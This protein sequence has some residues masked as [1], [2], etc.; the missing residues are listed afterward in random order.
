MLM[1]ARARST[2]GALLVGFAVLLLGACA[3]GGGGAA[4]SASP[5]SR[6]PLDAGSI[7]VYDDDAQCGGTSN[8][9]KVENPFYVGGSGLAPN[10]PF[11]LTFVTQPGGETVL[12]LTGTTTPE[13]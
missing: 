3:E 4:S 1:S 10:Q 6:G 7:N 5:E 12:T 2:F 9:S 8:D 11:T 13:G